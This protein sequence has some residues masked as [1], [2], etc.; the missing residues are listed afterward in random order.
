MVRNVHE[1]VI[2]ASAHSVGT[3]IDSLAGSDDLLWPRGEWPAMRFDRQLQVG[4][5]GGH[6][7]VGYIVEDYKP[8]RL[9]RFRFNRPAGFL[10]H[11][12]FFVRPIS[13]DSCLLRHELTMRTR[14]VALLAWPVFFRP[15]HDALLEECLDRAESAF[16]SSADPAKR[17]LWVRFLRSAAAM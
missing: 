7:P 2:P 14:G 8:G 17:S 6:G 4:A 15:L 12:Q 11:H 9:V 1:R 3:L 5:S 16:D 10:G 13:A